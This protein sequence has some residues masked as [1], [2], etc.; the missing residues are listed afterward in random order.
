M[1]TLVRLARDQGSEFTPDTIYCIST[2]T[3]PAN[4][5]RRI[6]VDGGYKAG[7]QF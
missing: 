3:H 2:N 7:H 5:W 4:A 1:D 6:G